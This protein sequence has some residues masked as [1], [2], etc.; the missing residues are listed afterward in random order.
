MEAKQ[1][2]LIDS[3]DR[4]PQSTVDN[5]TFE[6]SRPIIGTRKCQV[7]FCMTYNT[8]F[9]VIS[10]YNTLVIDGNTIS[11]SPGYYTGSSIVNSVDVTLKTIDP[12][13]GV[14][15]NSI[16]GNASFILGAHTITSTPLSF[17]MLG[18]KAAS[19][20]GSFQTTINTTYPAVLSFHSPELSCDSMRTTNR[21][22]LDATPFLTVPLYAQY[23]NLNY[24]QSNFPIELSCTTTNMSRLTIFMR[25]SR[26]L[27]IQNP[28]E[29]QLQLLFY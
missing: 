28:S 4:S 10:P 6:L 14:T 27:A 21:N 19:A 1:I 23:N 20:T 25:D 12:S 17:E 13:L 22:Q 7:L 18:I 8:L 5:A 2:L 29:Y 15:Y 16:S 26:G 3:R 11:I 24:Y 9:N